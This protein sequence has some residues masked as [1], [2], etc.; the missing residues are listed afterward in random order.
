MASDTRIS[1]CLAGICNDKEAS[2][3]DIL[4]SSEFIATMFNHMNQTKLS[5]LEWLFSHMDLTHTALGERKL[6]DILLGDVRTQTKLALH[7][8]CIWVFRDVN[9]RC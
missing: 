8:L 1:N 3:F 7:T 9:K 4:E 6:G 2:W 5:V